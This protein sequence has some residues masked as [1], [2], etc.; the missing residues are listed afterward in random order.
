MGWPVNATILEGGIGASYVKIKLESNR[1]G[2]RS[3]ISYYTTGPIDM[4]EYQREINL[5]WRP[6]PL[7]SQDILIENYFESEINLN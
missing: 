5:R 6:P 7:R 2:I 3:D 4:P 1:Q